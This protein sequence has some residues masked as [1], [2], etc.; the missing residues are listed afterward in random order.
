MS[1]QIGGGSK[2]QSTRDPAAA[3]SVMEWSAPSVFT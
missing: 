1:G 2:S 3:A